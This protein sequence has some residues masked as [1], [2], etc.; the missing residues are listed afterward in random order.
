MKDQ[1][2]K[3]YEKLCEKRNKSMKKKLSTEE[4]NVSV[5]NGQLSEDNTDI[6]LA[7]TFCTDCSVKHTENQHLDQKL[8]ETKSLLL[9]YQ[10]H[11]QSRLDCNL[12]IRLDC[13]VKN[14]ENVCFFQKNREE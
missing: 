7:L 4:A 10:I 1:S 9:K 11:L 6:D 13:K 14:T 8:N 12:Q 3:R 5:V 2:R